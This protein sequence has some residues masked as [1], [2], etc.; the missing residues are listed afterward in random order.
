MGDKPNKLLARKLT[1]R[2]YTPA[3][4]KLRLHN[5]QITQN[6]Q[7]ILQEFFSF[8]SKLY[9]TPTPLQATKA[10]EFLSDITLPTLERDHTELMEAEFTAGEVAAAI[11]HINP[12]KAPG[13]DGF[14]GHYYRKYTEILVPH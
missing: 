12:S 7:L 10:E 3:L 8:Y 13:P 6:P 9:D 5:G 14:S 11:K 2:P 1:P 4:P